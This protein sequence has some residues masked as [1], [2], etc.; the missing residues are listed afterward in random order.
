MG[1]PDIIELKKKAIEIRKDILK[2]LMIAGSGHTGGS[3]SIVDILVAL[4][5]HT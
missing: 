1:S 5:Y 3:L 2:M 4:Y